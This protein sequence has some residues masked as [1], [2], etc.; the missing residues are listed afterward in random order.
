MLRTKSIPM[1]LW[2]FRL[3][4]NPSLLL[5]LLWIVAILAV[6]PVSTVHSAPKRVVSLNLCADELILALAE[7]DQI[8]SL[9]WLSQDPEMTW[10]AAQ[11]AGYPANRGGVEEILQYQPDLVLS[12][13]YTTVLTQNLLREL[14]VPV[15]QLDLPQNLTQAL[16]QIARVG[17]ALV[18]QQRAEQLQQKI[19]QAAKQINLSGRSVVVYYPNG[20]TT[21]ADSLVDSVLTAAGLTN[22]A[23]DSGVG[24][25]SPLTI[26]Q[27]LLAQPDYLIVPQQYSQLPSL[28]DQLLAHPALHRRFEATQRLT[29]PTQAWSCGTGH[30]VQAF[31]LL[32]RLR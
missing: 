14:G 7:P 28:A 16:Q 30:L 1:S 23:A 22:V 15:L 8:A 11:A 19:Q 17:E 6:S 26:E 27:L 12:G 13:R 32:D 10:D 31:A 18:Q 29:V 5:C 2:W 25:F 4:I 24:A 21:G 20:F 3:P 9:S